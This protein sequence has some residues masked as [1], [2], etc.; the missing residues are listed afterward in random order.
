LVY[1]K[2]ACAQ[3]KSIICQFKDEKLH[4]FVLVTIEKIAIKKEQKEK[5]KK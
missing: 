3:N 1:G 5:N 4:W 2:E